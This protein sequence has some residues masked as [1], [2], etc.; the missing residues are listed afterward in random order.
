[1]KPDLSPRRSAAV[2]RERSFGHQCRTLTIGPIPVV[3]WFGTPSTSTRHGSSG[4]ERLDG[5][6][7]AGMVRTSR[8]FTLPLFSLW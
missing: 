3:D 7:A 1:M 2:Q 5:T 6:Q 8:N 4:D